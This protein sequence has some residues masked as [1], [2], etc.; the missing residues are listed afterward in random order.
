MEQL[1]CQNESEC[2]NWLDEA[3]NKEHIKYYKYDQFNNV[4]IIGSGGFGKVFRANWKNTGNILALKE[5]KYDTA[6]KEIINEV[7]VQRNSTKSLRTS[8]M[9]FVNE[10]DEYVIGL[11]VNRSALVIKSNFIYLFRST[12]NVKSIFMKISY[13]SLELPMKTVRIKFNKFEFS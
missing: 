8:I 2:I 3:I 9:K 6:V 7:T 1:N 10:Y 12:C 5:F 13:D 11:K 4:K